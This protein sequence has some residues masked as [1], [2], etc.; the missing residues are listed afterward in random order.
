MARMQQ[1]EQLD[2][3]ASTD[4][5]KA[6]TRVDGGDGGRLGNARREEE[7]EEEGEA[8]KAQTVFASIATGATVGATAST[9]TTTTTPTTNRTR[10]RE[11]TDAAQLRDSSSTLV[12]EKIIKLAKMRRA[13]L[14]EES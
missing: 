11:K 9:K 10:E 4:F 7:G 2:V 12:A 1:R 8:G 3:W 13:K 5:G 14:N 6:K